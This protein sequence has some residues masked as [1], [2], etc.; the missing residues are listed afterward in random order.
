MADSP[1][2]WLISCDESGVGGATHYGFGSLWMRWERRGD[3]SALVNELREKHGYTHECKWQKVNRRTIDF[4]RDLVEEFFKRN[5][6][7]FHC[8]VV[9][10][11]AVDK[12]HHNSWDEA[13]R[14]HFTM[15]LTNKIERCIERHRP[16][17]STFRIWVDPIHSNYQKADEVVEII[18]NRVLVNAL[19]ERRAVDRVLTHDSHDT[20]SIQLCDLLLGAV[21]ET[22]V[23]KSRTREK[24]SLR[25]WI[26][27][28]LGWDELDAD[29]RPGERKFNVWYFFDPPAGRREATTRA[30]RLKYP[31]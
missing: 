13:R 28:H 1:L 3:F 6:L 5:W 10:V 29:T 26:A 23:S 11:G 21:M 19:G 30:V 31:L 15:L 17:D 4:Y 25:R 27:H 8:I 18:A 2:N 24:D 22:W 7:A 9:R 12:T 16:R 14:K 20:P